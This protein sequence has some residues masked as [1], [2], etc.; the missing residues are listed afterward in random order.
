MERKISP[1]THYVA[2]EIDIDIGLL[3]EILSNVGLPVCGIDQVDNTELNIVDLFLIVF[4]K[5]SPTTGCTAQTMNF[6][7]GGFCRG[8]E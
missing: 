3:A 2:V 8:R 4:A 1:L 5:Q 7:Q 6:P